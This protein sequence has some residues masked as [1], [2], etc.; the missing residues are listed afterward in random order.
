[1]DLLIIY[2]CN[3]GENCHC[4][5]QEWKDMDI[6]SCVDEKDAKKTIAL[7]KENT[8]ER[9]YK[10]NRYGRFDIESAYIIEKELE[11]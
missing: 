4:H 10:Q 7:E 8:K 5:R 3:N 11:V 6:I 9:Y 1:M 2:E